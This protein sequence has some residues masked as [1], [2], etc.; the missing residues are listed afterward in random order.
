MPANSFA[1][2]GDLIRFLPE[3]ILT[4]FGTLLMVLDPVIR[5]KS[6]HAFGHLSIVGLLARLV[7][8][9]TLTRSRGPLLAACWWSTA[10][11][12]SSACW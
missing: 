10:S 11:L 2:T 3:I 5:K 8:R 9:S 7:A 1:S 6:S 12:R 4:V